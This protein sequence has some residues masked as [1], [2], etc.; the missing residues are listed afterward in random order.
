MFPSHDPHTPGKDVVWYNEAD[1]DL[2][3]VMVGLKFDTV[4]AG[5]QID[6]STYT[7]DGQ[8]ILRELSPKF[9]DTDAGGSFVIAEPLD[10]A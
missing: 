1:S 4:A 8:F 7:T 6:A 10:R 2:S 5:D 9:N 3:Q